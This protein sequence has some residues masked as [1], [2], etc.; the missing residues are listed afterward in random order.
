[1]CSHWLK[2]EKSSCQKPPSDHSCHVCFKLAYWFQ[3]RRLLNIF[4]IWSYV[5]TKSSH[6]GH[7]EFPIGK[8]FT[9]CKHGMDDPYVV[10]FQICVQWPWPPSKM[11][12][13]SRHS[14]NIEPYGEKCL[15]GVTGYNFE[16]WPPKDHSCHVCFKLT[17]WFQRRRLLNIFSIGFYVK[18]KSSHGMGKR[19]SVSF[20]H[21]A[22]LLWNR[23]T[24]F[25]QTCHKC[26]LDG[27]LPDRNFNMAATG[28]SCFRLVAF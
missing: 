10:N 26:S 15:I 25:N 2:F 24:D 5:K 27:A 12:A 11:A 8:R 14:F 1:M 16:S 9:S 28:N 4:S 21:L 7:L 23:W 13:F 17:Y 18:T 19:P 22:L 3:R 6:G 20:S